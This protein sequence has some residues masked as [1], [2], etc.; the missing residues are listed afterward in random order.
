MIKLKLLFGL[1]LSLIIGTTGFVLSFKEYKEISLYKK[2]G[3]ICIGYIYQIDTIIGS[4]GGMS[5]IYK[6]RFITKKDENITTT[7]LY[8]SN[9]DLYKLNDSVKIIYLENHPA[10]SRFYSELS[11][12]L[13]NY[14]LIMFIIPLVYIIIVSIFFRRCLCLHKRQC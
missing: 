5:K 3:I 14:Y 11:Y 1:V 6:A 4:E 13:L 9:D 12:K 8:Q 2:N 7:N 10:N